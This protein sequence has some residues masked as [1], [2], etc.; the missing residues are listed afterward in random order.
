MT[1]KALLKNPETVS[2]RLSLAWEA[3]FWKVMSCAAFAG[4][5]AVVR[6]LEG[7][8]ALAPETVLSANVILFFQNLFAILFMVPVTLPFLFKKKRLALMTHHPKLHFLRVL[9]AVLGVWLWYL[10]LEN[11]PIAEGV[12]LS[13][14]GP[15]F[16]VIGARLLL[17]ESIGGQRLLAILLSLLGA[18]IIMR[19]DI[20][21]L[22]SEAHLGW[23]ALFPLASAIVLAL[24][25]LLTR[26]LAGFGESPERLTLYL[27]LG[28]VPVSGLTAWYEWVSPSLSHWPWLLLLGLL[29][30]LAHL[31]FGKAY[32]LAEVSFLMPFGFSKF[33]FSACLGYYCF[34]EFPKWSLWMG[35]SI[36][37]FSILLLGYKISLYSTAKRFK[38][39]WF[40]NRE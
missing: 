7:G 15:V 11:M 31:S 8:S 35:M 30:G 17:R 23:V 25:K 12:A 22:R 37:A 32:K 24:N 6:Y 27:L 19:P 29:A 13:F 5:N 26:Q 36:I 14:T 9:L 18:F 2:L 33:L 3:A 38:S 16:T 28:M 40:K 39:N 34:S 1:Y 20:A 10:T 4:I 21:L